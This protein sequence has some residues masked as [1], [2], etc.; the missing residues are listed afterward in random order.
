MVNSLKLNVFIHCNSGLSRSPAVLITYM[1]LFK[2]IKCWERAEDVL[3]FVKT[4]NS[5]L[6]PN[7]RVIKKCL[8]TNKQFQIN[9]LEGSHTQLK[10]NNQIEESFYF[11]NMVIEESKLQLV[12]PIQNIRND[13]QNQVIEE[14]EFDFASEKQSTVKDQNKNAQSSR[15]S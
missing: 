12:N 3:K 8:A 11:P 13:I 2:K 9:Q 1:C 14:E 4:M 6:C 7:M 15:Q 10:C 5:K